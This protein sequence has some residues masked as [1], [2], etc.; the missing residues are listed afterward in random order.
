MKIFYFLS[1]EYFSAI[2]PEENYDLF[3]FVENYESSLVSKKNKIKIKAYKEWLI[4][5]FP[6][7]KKYPVDHFST[8]N[9]TDM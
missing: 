4:N 9:G 7:I 3:C 2:L 6:D 1:K 5:R 8:Q